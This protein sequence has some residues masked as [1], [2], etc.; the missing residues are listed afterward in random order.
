M[1]LQWFLRILLSATLGIFLLLAAGCSKQQS[2]DLSLLAWLPATT[3]A[4][5]L[6]QDPEEACRTTMLGRRFPVA[7]SP[8]LLLLFQNEYSPAI[9]LPAAPPQSDAAPEEKTYRER[10]Y[11]TRPNPL[12]KKSGTPAEQEVWARF[13]LPNGQTVVGGEAAVMDVIDVVA[14]AK[15]SLAKG[16]PELRPMLER[17]AHSGGVVDFSF[18]TQSQQQSDESGLE[19]I[20]GSWPVR[21]A[22]GPARSYRG[23]AS[24]F[25]RDGARCHV[26]YGVQLSSGVAARLLTAAMA[27]AVGAGTLAGWPLGP[28]YLSNWNVNRESELVVATLDLTKAGC[29]YWQQKQQ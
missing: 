27:A 25:D 4:L 23:R 24:R 29:D 3:T 19:A 9:L 28:E 26:T 7:V 11:A 10:R 13:V 16:R 21:T 22:L 6:C 2:A 8:G 14:G 12:A 20:L 18:T 5:S 1:L 15:P 17:F